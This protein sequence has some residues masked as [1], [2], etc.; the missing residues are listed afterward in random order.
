MGFDAQITDF[1]GIPIQNFKPDSLPDDLGGIGWRISIDWEAYEAG[2][3]FSEVFA[4]LLA[5]PGAS[6][7]QA[8][9]VGCWEGGAEGESSESVIEALVSAREQLPNLKHLFIGEMLQEECEVS[10]INQ[11]D[12]S[13][14]FL[15]YPKLLTLR[16]R[17]SQG[18]SLGRPVHENLRNLIIEGG[19][20]PGELVSEVTSAR[21]PNLVH[22]E[23]WLG[24]DG[25]G[26]SVRQ[27]E[28][29]P[30]L[31]G[32]LFPKLKYLGLR[33]DSDID[34]TVTWLQ[35]A[36]LLDQLSV[37]DISLGTLSDL[38]AA[39]LLENDGLKGLKRLNAFFNFLSDAAADSLTSALPGVE[40]DVSQQNEADEYD[41]DAYRYNFVS[42]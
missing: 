29:Q 12:I 5:L 25:Y 35:G 2:R 10:W 26:R 6:E 23:L 7:L 11:S 39:A 33:N 4:Q 15:A 14:I 1:E 21:L 13:P 3:K 31:D 24:D 22:L 30:I 32:G 19:G 36:K 8:L 20:M 28:L 27:E 40:V 41:G 34:T 9:I 16:V 37:L 18:L 42:E 38:G 17:G